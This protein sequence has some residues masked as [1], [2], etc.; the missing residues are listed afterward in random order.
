MADDAD[1]TDVVCAMAVIVV[2][3]RAN[4]KGKNDNV[5]PTTKNAAPRSLFFLHIFRG[6]GGSLT[7]SA[8]SMLHRMFQ[9]R[10]TSVNT[11]TAVNIQQTVI[12]TPAIDRT[13]AACI[14]S[15]HATN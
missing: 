5:D 12:T 8:Q 10:Q 11:T 15:L 6:E 2:K 1:E 13:S 9:I 7:N 4:R 14:A 3:E